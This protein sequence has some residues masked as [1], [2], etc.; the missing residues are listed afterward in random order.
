[1]RKERRDLL[2]LVFRAGAGVVVNFVTTRGRRGVRLAVSGE[3]G[4]EERRNGIGH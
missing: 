1:M 3:R 4:A 2:P